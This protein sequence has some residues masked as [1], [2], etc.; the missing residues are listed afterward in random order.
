MCI[1]LGGKRWHC[2]KEST[3]F[4]R[5]PLEGTNWESKFPKE[6][7]ILMTNFHTV[8]SIFLL[9]FHSQP[10]PQSPRSWGTWLLFPQSGLQVSSAAWRH[11]PNGR[12][13]RLPFNQR[14]GSCPGQ[15]EKPHFHTSATPKGSPLKEN[16]A[17]TPHLVL[18]LSGKKAGET[19]TS[20]CLAGG[21]SN[22]P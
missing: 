11:V 3:E 6:F 9:F 20:F 17:G 18:T 7:W 16:L 1:G 12:G 19:D 14:C 13:L 22:C 2:V 21:Q 4:F 8:F 15:E 10:P 5:I